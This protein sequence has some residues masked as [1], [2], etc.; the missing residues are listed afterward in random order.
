LAANSPYWNG[1]DTG[2][3]S[4]RLEVWARW[5]TAS[6]PPHLEDR[7]A[8][9]DVVAQLRTAGAIEDTTHLYWHARPSARYPTLE[10]RTTDVCLAVDDAVTVAGVARGLTRA[11][12]RE[13]QEGV[14]VDPIATEVLDA[15]LWR[16]ARYGLSEELVSPTSWEPAPADLVVEELLTR[17]GPGLDELGDREEVTELVGRILTRGNGASRQRAAQADGGD[18]R[19]V[20]HAVR[21]AAA[22]A[23]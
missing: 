1:E 12:L 22:V 16:A 23:D 11:C 15:A 20:F 13:A 17:I 10:F 21:A 8:Y 9:D 14:A 5:P 7:A 2:Y 6:V 18:L 3:D 4:Y 19:E